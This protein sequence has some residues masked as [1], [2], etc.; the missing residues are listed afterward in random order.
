MSVCPLSS[1]EFGRMV[2]LSGQ[3]IQRLILPRVGAGR[4]AGF[5]PFVCVPIDIQSETRSA[6]GIAAE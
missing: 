4:R 1:A 3:Q 2:G 5:D 6:Y